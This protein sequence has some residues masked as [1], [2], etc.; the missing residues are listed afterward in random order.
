MKKAVLVIVEAVVEAIITT[1]V[2][3]TITVGFLAAVG[4]IKR[5]CK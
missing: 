4:A 3:G 1:A 5:R 2:A